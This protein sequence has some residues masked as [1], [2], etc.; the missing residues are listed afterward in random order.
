LFVAIYK[1]SVYTK[2]ICISSLAV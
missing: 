2:I 1:P